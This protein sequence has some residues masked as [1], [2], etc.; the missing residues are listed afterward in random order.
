[1]NEYDQKAVS[2]RDFIAAAVFYI[3]SFLL[4]PVTL[5]GYVIYVGYLFLVGRTP[6][7]STTAQGPL[8]ARWAQHHLGTRQ[9]EAANRLMTALPGFF[10]LGWYLVAGPTLLAHRLTGY[11]PK[12]F[13]YPFEGEV[14][15]QYQASARQTFFDGVVE[16]YLPNITQ[17]VILG[18]GFDTRAY[19]LPKDARVQSF[20][21]DAPQTQAVKRELL[22]KTGIDS[23]GVTFVS[24]D[25][26]KEDWLTRLV[27][28]GFDPGKP[29]LFLLEGV[30]VYL[31][32]EA[33]ESTLRKI[34]STAKGSVVAFDYFTTEPLESRA[35]Y[36]RYGRAATKAA[37][38]PL[39]FGVDSTPPSRER[40]AEFLRSCG[41]SLGEQ[42]T[43]GQET[44][45]KR[46]WG[47]FA[48]AIVK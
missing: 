38:E 9:D 39:K 48:T 42:R 27:Q 7:V 46:A 26:E 21:V 5:I 33:V 47:G 40:L 43:L 15:V 1:V 17:F 32:R 6:G 36:W 31:D 3:L 19:R 20:E 30:I 14:P 10:P 16:R 24:A 25:F 2:A 28:A 29:A 8:S 44:E 12:A 11:V 23:T 13:R 41:L 45:G 4:F 18:A 22:N 37:G 35:L 34:A